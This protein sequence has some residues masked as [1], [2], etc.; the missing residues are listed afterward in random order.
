MADEAVITVRAD[1][2]YLIKGV[3][4][5][6][7]EGKEIPATARTGP[8][9][10]SIRSSSELAAPPLPLAPWWPAGRL[11]AEGTQRRPP[12]RSRGLPLIR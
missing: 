11:A 9:A 10:S 6:N 12:R 3:K 1:G 2:P 7:H 8:W 5:V 4:L